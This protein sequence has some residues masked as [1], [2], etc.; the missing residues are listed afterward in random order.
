MDRNSKWQNNQAFKRTSDL[1]ISRDNVDTITKIGIAHLAA[2]NTDEFILVMNA[3]G[4]FQTQN[5]TGEL[6]DLLKQLIANGS[7]NRS[8]D[9]INE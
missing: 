8:T 1:P 6:K 3:L 5:E 7:N 9:E 4:K 2:G